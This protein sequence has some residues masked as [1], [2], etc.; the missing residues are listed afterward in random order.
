LLLG[1]ASKSLCNR[2]DNPRVRKP[3][4]RRVAYYCLVIVLFF[5]V[6]ASGQTTNATLSGTVLDPQNAVIPNTRISAENI[7]TGI[8]VTAVTNDAGIYTFPSIPPG[9]YRLTGEAPGFRTQ[10]FNDV[11]V[12]V[13]ARMNINFFLQVGATDDTVEVTAQAESLLTGTATVGSVISG[14]RIQELPLSQRN[15]LDLVETQAG[16]VRDNFAGSRMNAVNVTIDGVN[17]MD[18]NINSGVS[19]AI[20]PNTDNVEEVRVVTSPVDAEF[21]R[22]SGQVQIKTKSGS[23]DFH[24]NVYEQ[25]SNTSLNANRWFNNLRGQPRDSLILNNFGASLGGP[26]DR[27]RTF[28]YFNYDG[29]RNRSADSVTALTYTDTARQGVFRFYPGVQNGNANAAVPTVDLVGNPVRPASATGPLQSV[30]LFGR[31]PFRPGPDPSRTIQRLLAVM[32]APNDFRTGDG[33]NTAGY[34]WRRRSTLDANQYNAKIDHNFNDSHRAEITFARENVNAPN[35]FM[36]QSF[37]GSPG[38]S[39]EQG[40]SLYAVSITS[41]LS[42]TKLNEFHAGALRARTRFFAPWELPGGRELM[43]TNN[44]YGYLPSFSLID[45]PIPTNNDPQ[46]RISPFYEYRDVFHFQ[47]GKHAVKS[48]G[49][50]R[51]ASTNG[52]EQFGIMPRVTFGYGFG[53]GFTGINSFSIP[54]LGANETAAQLTLADLAGSVD[55][56]TQVFNARLGP[57]PAFVAGEGR[58]RTWR[59]REFAFF[60]QDDFK[61][62]SDLTLNLGMRYEAYG[63][64]WDANGRTSA[65]VGGS[66]GLFGIS[67]TSWADMYQPGHLEGEFT[68]VQLIGKKSPRPNVQLYN[69]DWNNFAPVV[70]MSWSIPWFGRS[71]TVLRAGYSVSYTREGL[72]LT[73]VVAGNEPGLRTS[74]FDI[75]SGY[76][77]LTNIH[78]PLQPIGRPLETVPLT[79]RVQAAWAFDNN[80]RTPYIQNW[81]LS[82]QR[83]LPGSFTLDV[84]YVGSKGTKLIRSVNVNE[85][86]IFENGLADAFRI[87]QAGGNAPIFD[88]IFEGFNLGLGVVDGRNVTGSASLRAF[89]STRGYLATNN[90]GAFASFLNTVGAFDGRGGLLRFSDLPENWIVANPQFGGALYVGNFSNS[91]YHSLQMETKKRLSKGLTV[92]ANYTWGRTLGDEE[93]SSQD[94]LNSYRNGRDRGIDK[95][96]LGFHRTHIFR[97]NGTWELPFGPNHYFLSGNGILS[98]LA[99]GWQIGGIFNI[100]SGGPISLYSG[101]SS[102]NQHLDNTATLVGTLPKSTGYVKRTNNGVV[103]FSD[104]KQ[105]PDPMIATLTPLQLLNTR[106]TLKAIADES[107][108]VIAVNPTPGRLGSLSQ[109]YLQGPG[110]FRL[111]VNLMK[112][113]PLREGKEIQ[114]RADAVNVLNSPVF[115]SPDIN[116]NSTNFG[117]INNAVGNRVV[118]LTGRINF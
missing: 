25:N 37:P 82:I 28:F 103:Y 31:D 110:E 5:S 23:K 60:V 32:P 96:L 13:G 14:Q 1:K 86:N 12:A 78:L 75:S 52:F 8:V 16:V 80:L 85:V 20:F 109:T 63:V 108:N 3:M 64:P 48:G 73:D 38:G 111:D 59:Q 117:R 42:P 90:I 101:V 22:G 41:T 87:T 10:V 40:A 56:V 107:G 104:L 93:G 18:Q 7:A 94:L 69:N 34:T 53:P 88:Q 98:R 115:A 102:F 92:E 2:C 21:G 118:L 67:G 76:V 51:F 43:P 79:D 65:L 105:V 45:D 81:N 26:I 24:G 97:S 54:G 113:I 99:G 15:A 58:Q 44:G 61:L 50:L 62:R 114:I 30:S 29:F 66:T 57:K 84:R 74:G 70:G 27:E 33:L 6:A 17:V 39:A 11:I 4:K 46:G 55:N 100:A 47:K 36:P 106:S 95:R 112:K 89:T 35:G 19:S 71:R 116:I 83:E 68:Q 9:T 77:D 91:T 72:V 49:E